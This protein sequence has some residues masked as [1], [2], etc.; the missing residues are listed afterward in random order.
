[1]AYAAKV[2]SEQIADVQYA[3]NAAQIQW[4]Q[5]HGAYNPPPGPNGLQQQAVQVRIDWGGEQESMGKLEFALKDVQHQTEWE[6][7]V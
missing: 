4:Q 5:P 3:L 6:G 1:M 2:A 7:Q